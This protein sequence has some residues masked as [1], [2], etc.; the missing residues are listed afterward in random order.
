MYF[1]TAN[2]I[3]YYDGYTFT[4]LDIDSLKSNALLSMTI[5]DRDQLYLSISEEGIARYSLKSGSYELL[6]HL[7]SAGHNSD[8]FIITET[9]A[10]LLTT[11]IKLLM[12]D[13]KSNRLIQDELRK[14]NESDVPNCLYKTKDSR[15]LVG[16]NSGLYEIQNGKQVKL[17]FF[18]N[19]AVYSICESNK[20]KMYIGSS[21]KIVVVNN[22][23][24][25]SEITPAFNTRSATF[26]PGGEKSITKLVV[27]EY[28]RLWFTS[29]PDETLYMY[30][31][32]TAY[33][34]FE[35]LGIPPTLINCMYKDDGENIWLGTYSDG[36]YYIQNPF[37]NT[38]TFSY[39][40]KNLAV[41][42]VY[43]KGN[44]LVA[45]TS[46][47]L[48]GLNRTNNQTK[49]LSKPDDMFM[50]P[51]NSITP[52]DGILYYTKRNQFDMS[53]AMFFDSKNTYKFKPVI[54]RQ[55]YSL[56]K[57]QSVI[58]DWYANILLCNADGSKILDTL[59]SFP[60]YKL[61]V[62]AFLKRDQNLYIATNKGLVVYDFSTKKYR[63][64][65]RSELNFNINDIALINN[66]L[67][68]AHESGITDIENRKLIQQ[69]GKFR[70]NSVKKIKAFNEEVWLATL[71]G[72]IICDQNFEPV[73]I[74][75]KTNGLPSNSVNDIS[76]NEQT[77][78]IATARGIATTNFKNILKYNARLKPVTIHRV[79]CNG[80]TIE[81]DKNG[82]TFL[83]AQENI[84]VSFYSP[85]YNKPNKQFF[86]WRIDNGN[87][88]SINAP[89]FDVTLTGGKH[90]IEISVSADNISWS[91]STRLPL[92]KE[93]KLT[94]KQSLYWVITL[95]SLGCIIL[96]SF[97]WIRNVKV[98]AKKRLQE[99]QQ[100]NL[101]KH[102]AMNALLSPHF[103]FNSL[104]SIQNYINT[105]NSLKASE[106]L[107][108][109]SR[110]IR[111]IIEKAAQSH[112][113]L[114]DELAR[115]TYYLELEKERF[116]NK[117]DYEI[118]IDE[119]LHTHEVH[120]PNMII[121]PHV[122]NCIL[123]GIL[124]KHEHGLLS[125]RFQKRGD[126]ELRITIEDNGIGLI[127]A[128]EHAKTGHKSLGTSTIRNILELNSKLSGKKQ[129]V[130]M[131]DK[132][133]LDVNQHG[134]LITIDIEL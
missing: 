40:N 44:L 111:M 127:K 120:I 72:V 112:I 49:I 56:Q 64:M 34:V 83:A 87:W 18:G 109:F 61:Q 37:F 124:P 19:R 35:A 102:Q 4:K 9:F 110:L 107:A 99:E 14:K 58:A 10:Y 80:I 108:K 20:G 13:L 89:S 23:T 95:L 3:Y 125:I 27:D 88:I 1:T 73:K 6:N 71:D 77:V 11:R 96:I 57:D 24:L 114:H 12:V 131:V 25:E 45:A 92:L 93:E 47:G 84:S 43:V 105:N 66:K 106:Y 119:N 51:V 94:E 134:T 129:L 98:K 68:A 54:A 65:I 39:N 67:Y 117:F 85:F 115:L 113:S 63:T 33:D 74:L 55:F 5:Q 48:Y 41:N 91:E 121:Q 128:A 90:L 126:K 70:L 52:L 50:E 86:R 62:N 75:N 31:N 116:K 104:T 16:R 101:L 30:Y 97:I 133:T 100:V 79:T 42:Q 81:A 122:E 2:G 59:I 132:S 123:H 36:V 69:L 82:Y 8:N 29:N 15:I 28:G 38:F 32:S 130:S 76:F 78:N 60:D 17:N 53:P 22:Q 103:I 7:K 118:H 26:L 21:G 46:N